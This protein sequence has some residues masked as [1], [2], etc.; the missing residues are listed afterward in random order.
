MYVCMYVC[1]G[2]GVIP[3]ADIQFLEINKNTLSVPRSSAVDKQKARQVLYLTTQ[4]A[5][6]SKGVRLVKIV[7]Q[8]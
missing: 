8:N 1:S 7:E 6:H 2:H 4:T 5:E 3:K